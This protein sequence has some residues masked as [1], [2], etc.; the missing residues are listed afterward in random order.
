MGKGLDVGTMNIVSSQLENGKYV[1]RHQRNMF[2]EMDGNEVT[3][4]MLQQANVMHMKR[5]NEYVIVGEDALNFSTVMNADAKRPMKQG[6]LAR[7]EK[8]AIPMMRLIMEKL[9][10][11]P[12]YANE[13]VYYTAPGNPVD[14]KKN[15]LYHQK[16]LEHVLRKIGYQP[17]VINEGL[18][19][20]YQELK[21][22]EFT[23]MG[24]SCGAGM[25]NVAL[26]HLGVP[27][28]SFSVQR[29]GDW[30][31]M[32]VTEATGQT[33]DKV[34]VE[35]EKKFRMDTREGLNQVQAALAIYYDA[36]LD[37]ATRWIESELRRVNIDEGV[38]VPVVITGGTS[39]PVGFVEAFEQRLRKAKLPFEIGVVRGG[40]SSL[41]TVSLGALVAARV[42]EAELKEQATTPA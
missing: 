10:G 15:I 37:Y 27:L 20:V 14:G 4:Q 8:E 34:T 16:I 25:V 28:T 33:K 1:I 22:Q 36:L 17:F 21:D 5:G 18:T 19:V 11:K 31:D 13:V 30:I 24:I 6:I 3:G 42:K 40:K 38:V 2:L 9:L 26:S 39:S 7:D 23:G 29:G 12:A 41:Y 35:K 32:Q